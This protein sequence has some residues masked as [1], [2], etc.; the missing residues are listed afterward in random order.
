MKLKNLHIFLAI[1]FLFLAS[2][3]FSPKGIFSAVSEHVVISE[4]QTAA[5]VSTDEFVELYNP[6]AEEV[7]LSGWELYRRTAAVDAEEQLVATMSGAIPAHGFYL[8]AHEDY[9]GSTPADIAYNTQNVANNN[10]L[11]LKNSEGVVVD[12]V[13]MGTAGLWEGEATENPIAG[14][15]IERKAISTSTVESMRAEHALFGNGWDTD[16]NAA[17]F[18]RHTSPNVSEP[19]NS[20]SD[21]QVPPAENTPIPTP[22]AV[23]TPTATPEATPTPEPTA[24][25]T[26]EATAT[27]DPTASPAPSPSP[28]AHP[29]PPGRVIAMFPTRDGVTVC[30]IE[31]EVKAHR[32]FFFSFPRIVCDRI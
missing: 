22:T 4:I 17:D 7:S 14:R 29:T 2:V 20:G 5:D 23:A 11:I 27:P 28:T 25:A 21:P 16:N 1:S 10:T 19:Q 18:V 9:T 15:S 13:G 32:F 31:W 6:T 3:I 24:T 26:P 30:R 12:L 8:V